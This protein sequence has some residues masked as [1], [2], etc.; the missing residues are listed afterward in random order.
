MIYGGLGILA[1]E[2]LG[3]SP[4]PSDPLPSVSS[5]GATNRKTEK[6]R[7]L[8]DERGE[9]GVGKEVNHTTA[10]SLVFFK[11]FSTL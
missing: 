10:R 11:T 9:K 5:T 7:Q 4:T 2:K 1:V 3:S 6:E 8:A